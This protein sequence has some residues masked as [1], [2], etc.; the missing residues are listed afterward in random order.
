MMNDISTIAHAHPH[1]QVKEGDV[2]G[3]ALDFTDLPML[4]FTAGGS[5]LGQ[6]DELAVMR[7][8][9]T[10]YPAVAVAGGA[11]VSVTFAGESLAHRPP[12]KCQALVVGQDMM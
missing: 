8:R 12:R 5:P 11:A 4:F 3:I 7:I 1:L 10:V 9:G 2:I 6:G